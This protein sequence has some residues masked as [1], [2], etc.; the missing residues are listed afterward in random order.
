MQELF[1]IMSRLRDPK[2]GC[3]W[4]LKQSFKSIVPY[5]LEEAY[6][7]ADC[8]ERQAYDDLPGELGDLLFQ[9]VFYAQLGNEE[10]LFCFEDIVEKLV[11]KLKER[12]PHVLR[13]E[14]LPN[15]IA[16]GRIK[17]RM[18]A[19]LR[20]KASIAVNL[21]VCLLAYQH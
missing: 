21:M 18:S 1:E 4:D 20:A 11:R 13:P 15:R 8:I 6:E 9:V 14:I 16:V 17:K 3:P 2:N 7:V 12:H 5:T 10:G 19:K